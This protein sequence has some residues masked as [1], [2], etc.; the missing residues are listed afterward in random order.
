LDLGHHLLQFDALDLVYGACIDDVAQQQVDDGDEG[1]AE[2][3]PP[4]A[5]DLRADEEGDDDEDGPADPFTFASR[6]S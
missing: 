6:L 5:G 4:R 3:G 2:D 1:D